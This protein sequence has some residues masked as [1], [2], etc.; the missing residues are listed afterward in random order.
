MVKATSSIMGECGQGGAGGGGEVVQQFFE[1][2]YV[3]CLS[4]WMGSPLVVVES[5]SDFG[6]VQ[7]FAVEQEAKRSIVICLEEVDYPKFVQKERSFK[8]V[9]HNIEYTPPPVQTNTVF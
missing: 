5:V 6:V 7:E 4:V 3:F 2:Q 8:F 9:D 1:H